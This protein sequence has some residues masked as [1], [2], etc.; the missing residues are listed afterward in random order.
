MSLLPTVETGHVLGG[1]SVICLGV[2]HHAAS[3]YD[4]DSSHVLHGH[5]P[6][7]KNGDLTP[8]GGPPRQLHGPRDNDGTHGLPRIATKRHVGM[9]GGRRGYHLV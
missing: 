7:G 4:G 8:A 1:T 5:N 3:E 6:I 2:G 9:R